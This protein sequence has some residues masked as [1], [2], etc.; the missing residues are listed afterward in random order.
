MI[1]FFLMGREAVMWN[2][3]IKKKKKKNEL[4]ACSREKYW[5][6]WMEASEYD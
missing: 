4:W 2:M 3:E 5:H 6:Q 1:F